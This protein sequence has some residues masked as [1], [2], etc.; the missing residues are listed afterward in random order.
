MTS[1]IKNNGYVF[2]IRLDLIFFVMMEGLSIVKDFK[3][4]SHQTIN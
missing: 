1:S 3:L 4:P 2:L